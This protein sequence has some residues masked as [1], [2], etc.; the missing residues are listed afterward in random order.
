MNDKESYEYCIGKNKSLCLYKYFHR[1]E[2]FCCPLSIFF[3]RKGQPRSFMHHKHYTR[4]HLWPW[5][6]VFM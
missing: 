2:L 3:L 5:T 4:Y 6:D 1:H